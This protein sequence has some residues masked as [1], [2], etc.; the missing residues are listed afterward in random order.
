MNVPGIVGMGA[1]AAI[2]ASRVS[3]DFQQLSKLR[4][5][6]ETM[7]KDRLP[8]IKVNSSES[9]RLP[10]TA[11]IQF[12]G[13]KA[14]ELVAQLKDLAVSTGSACA[15]ENTKPSHV[16][17]AMGLSKSE[18]RSTVRFSM[19]RFT[20]AQ[21]VAFAATHVIETVSAMLADKQAILKTV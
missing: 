17:T 20:T 7:L 3:D 4:N 21:E 15:S 11:N 13:L 1:A 6:F 10:Q 16:L 8:E 14:G 18:A 19:G 5:R 9:D 2:C 12:P